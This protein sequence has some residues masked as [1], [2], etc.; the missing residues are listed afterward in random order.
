MADQP[1][2]FDST[3]PTVET[4]PTGGAPVT[5]P[6]GDVVFADLLKHIVNENGQQ[7]Y[8]SIPKALEGL[9]HAQ[10]FIP[11]LKTEVQLKDAEIA[12]LR[13]ELE[14][15]QALEEVVG[16]LTATQQSTVKDEPPIT[17]GLDEQAVMNLVKQTLMQT[18]QQESAQANILKVQET[19]S[20]KYGEKTVE[21]LES[22]ARELGTTRQELGKLASQNP[23]LVL[24]LFNVQASPGAKPT[25][26][27]VTLPSSYQP[28]RDELKRPEKSLL[29]GSTSKEQAEFMRKIKED[30]Y[31][32]Y[33]VSQ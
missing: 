1:N 24:A 4:Q 7:K 19:L 2:L 25:T 27:S 33:G 22:K 8:D 11:Q 23:Q 5:Q 12:K 15:K 3:T 26:T 14:Q 16:R 31:A 13:A 30:V 20:S 18:K 6:S 32:K 17:S 9:A 10:N 21:V 29:S 28:A